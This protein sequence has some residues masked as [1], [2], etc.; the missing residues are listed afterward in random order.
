MTTRTPERWTTVLIALMMLITTA[1]AD[2]QADPPD[3]PGSGNPPAEADGEEPD[4]EVRPR[5]HTIPTCPSQI[6]GAFC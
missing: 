1:C 3:D 5:V 4:V 6:P 2:V